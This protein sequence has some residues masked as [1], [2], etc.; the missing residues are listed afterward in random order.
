MLYLGVLI[1]IEGSEVEKN[2][3]SL[4]FL[5]IYSKKGNQ[6]LGVIELKSLEEWNKI[7]EALQSIPGYLGLSILSSYSDEG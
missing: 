6:I 3:T 1:D 2:L 5:H 7:V 4:P